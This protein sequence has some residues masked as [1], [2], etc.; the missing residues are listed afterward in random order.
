MNHEFVGSMVEGDEDYGQD[1]E[2]YD[3]RSQQFNSYDTNTVCSNVTE[4]MSQ[5]LPGHAIDS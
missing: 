5:H 1:G 3:S 4:I 2:N